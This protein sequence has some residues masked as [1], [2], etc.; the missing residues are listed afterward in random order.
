MANRMLLFIAVVLFVWVS[1]SR[2]SDESRTLDSVTLTNAIADSTK[3]LENSLT[4]QRQ[5]DS[6]HVRTFRLLQ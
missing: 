3:M 4:D 2:V 1:C 6:L 5:L